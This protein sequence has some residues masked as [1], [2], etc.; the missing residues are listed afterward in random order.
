MG[1]RGFSLTLWVTSC[2]LFQAFAKNDS[3]GAHGD[4]DKPGVSS[5]MRID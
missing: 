4:N 2:V 1:H 5:E 3:L